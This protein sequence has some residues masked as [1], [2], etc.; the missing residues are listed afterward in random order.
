MVKAVITTAPIKSSQSPT[1]SIVFTWISSVPN[2]M[3][4][5]GVPTGSINE[6]LAAMV[7]GIITNNGGIP[8][9]GIIGIRIAINKLTVAV[10]L[11]NS[12][13]MVVITHN[14]KSLPIH[15]KL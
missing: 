6:K 10:L 9:S 14:A 5:G 2:T 1:R 15:L 3:V 4:L 8:S 7:T 12:E 11:A 13:K